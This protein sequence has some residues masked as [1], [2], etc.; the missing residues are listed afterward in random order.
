MQ[1]SNVVLAN[2]EKFDKEYDDYM[3][4]ES[5]GLEDVPVEDVLSYWKKKEKDY[6]I[7]AEISRAI[8][9]HQAS[10]AGI[11]RDFGKGAYL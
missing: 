1:N 6:L 3:D 2:K 8:Y 7:L 10:A 9:G 11:E 4:F 5:L